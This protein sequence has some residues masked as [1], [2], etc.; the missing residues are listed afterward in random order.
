MEDLSLLKII[1]KRQQN[2]HYEYLYTQQLNKHHDEGKHLPWSLHAQI[3]GVQGYK[4]YA[5][6]G[7]TYTQDEKIQ[8]GNLFMPLCSNARQPTSAN[9]FHSAIAL[10]N[11]NSVIHR[12]ACVTKSSLKSP[13]NPTL[14]HEKKS[15]KPSN[16]SIIRSLC[17]NVSNECTLRPYNGLHKVNRQFDF[18][19]HS[20]ENKTCQQNYPNLS[21]ANLVCLDDDTNDLLPFPLQPTKFEDKKNVPELKTELTHNK[22]QPILD[23]FG[24]GHTD[25]NNNCA[26]MNEEVGVQINTHSSTQNF[27]TNNDV[28]ML[29]LTKLFRQIHNLKLGRARNKVNQFHAK[30]NRLKPC[31]KFKDVD[32]NQV[33]PKTLIVS[34]NMDYSNLNKNSFDNSSESIVSFHQ[35]IRINFCSYRQVGLYF[36]KTVSH[37]SDIHCIRKWH[38]GMLKV[39]R[40]RLKKAKD[41]MK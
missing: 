33:K 13:A 32:L 41:M 21:K 4:S 9:A 26:L 37:V 23:A 40:K 36:T 34:V 7:L 5:S 3:F 38:R 31:I 8:R 25:C 22:L 10:L 18:V 14:K 16:L 29:F 1:S 12:S 35:Q 2:Q 19:K 30:Q 39:K 17:D 11:A 6:H 20:C 28:N 15:N 24:I 27:V